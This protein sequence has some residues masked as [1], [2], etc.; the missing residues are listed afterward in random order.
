MKVTDLLFKKGK[1]A[2]LVVCV[3]LLSASL[4]TPLF[5][6]VTSETSDSTSVGAQIWNLTN[7]DGQVATVIVEPFTNSGSFSETSSS[8]GWWMLD[9]VGNHAFRFNVGGN[10]FHA[11]GGDNWDFVNF[12]GSGNGY[13]S[14]G[15]ATGT[16]NGNFPY[17]TSV[18]GTYTLTTNSGYGTAS[19]SG[20]WSGVLVSG[21][22][23]GTQ[24]ATPT[25]SGQLA[26]RYYGGVGSV[27]GQATD[28]NGNTPL[29]TGQ[30]VSGTEIQTGSNGIVGFEPPN[31][32]GE[33]Y[34]GANSDAGWVGLTSEP[35]PDNGITYMI[36][37]L[38]SSGTI[39]P[40]GNE[41]LSDLKYSI[42]LDI[43]LAVLVF[44]HPLGQAAA[45]G[46]FVEGGAFL[47]PNGVAYIKETV[48]HLIAVPQGALAGENTEYT[49][50]V[51]SDGTTAV[52]VIAGPVIFMDPISN[53]T[54]TVNTNQVLTLPSAQQNGFTANELQSYVSSLTP[55]SVNQW[56]TQAS[57]STFS[58]N[59][60]MSQNVII[61]IVAVVVIVA[62]AAVVATVVRKRKVIKQIHE[63]EASI[64]ATQ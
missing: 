55:S 27:K 16:A 37:P 2:T 29:S 10:I 59:D 44:S 45:V 18:S 21:A 46:L 20:T 15:T 38:V 47:I 58:L 23:S 56:W 5:A 53:N 28:A 39:F 54:I 14:M 34:L 40:N 19:G 52:Q 48:S 24:G 13:Q 1:M 8:S 43:A 61:A 64:N 32:G 3:V 36:Y 12:G 26:A 17:A 9:N 35:A 49:V 57:A 60:L 33:V 6:Q 31:Q 7:D 30:I 4:V 25:P 51:S 63:S 62:L 42:P 50:N 41:Q 11:S 22:P